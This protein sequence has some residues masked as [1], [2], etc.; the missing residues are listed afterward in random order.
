MI[1]VICVCLYGDDSNDD[2]DSNAK[3]SVKDDF[4]GERFPLKTRVPV[5]SKWE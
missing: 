2:D 4:E 3:E 1:S 5:A